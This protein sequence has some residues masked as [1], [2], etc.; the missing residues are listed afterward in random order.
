MPS[1]K[2]IQAAYKL[3]REAYAEMGVDTEAAMRQLA[4][5]P[6]SLHCWQGDDVGGFENPG[7]ELTGGIAV[8]GNYPGKARTPDELRAD[9]EKTYSLLPGKHR[10]ALHAIYAETGGKRV[11]RNELEPSHFAR[12]IGW[13]KSQKLGLDFNPTF[14]S[15][16]KA[17][18]GFTLAHRDKAVRQFWIEHGIACRKIGAAMGQGLGKTCVT[19]VWIPDGF[20]DIPVDRNGPRQRLE[21]SLDAVFA[22]PV[23][24]KFNLD[25]VEPK[26]FGLGSESYVVG[27]HEFYLGYAVRRKKLLC[28]DAGH[29]HPT[30]GI[31]DKISSV[32]SS[33]EEILLHVSRGVRWDSDHVVILTDELEAIA[34]ELVRGDFLGRTHIGLDYFDASI[35]RVAAWVIGTR[36]MIKALLLALLEPIGLL[37][38]A[39]NEGNLTARLALLEEAKTLPHGAVW[40]A[41]CESQ[42]APTGAGL[43]AEIQRYDKDVLSNRK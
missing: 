34:Q 15:H 32:L 4:K 43:L 22:K 33:V 36:C 17:A 7:G 41:Y 24:V 39:E 16:P 37:R 21:E 40:D 38:K 30:E 23:D 2:R 12:W 1:T 13:A 9:L 20:K 11:E 27:S 18:D 6:I 10:L 3:A 25:S 29:Y 35:N 8:T 5:I 42:G 28:L 19:N 31:A 26:L 14:F